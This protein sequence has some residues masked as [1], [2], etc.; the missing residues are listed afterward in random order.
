MSRKYVIM[1]NDPN[2]TTF[3]WGYAGRTIF[4]TRHEAVGSLALLSRL[5]PDTEY[6]LNVFG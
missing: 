1:F 5:N 2:W 4:D 3:E 6:E